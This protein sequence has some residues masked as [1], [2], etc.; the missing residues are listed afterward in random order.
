MTL[1]GIPVHKTYSGLKGIRL[2]NFLISS[3][4]PDE[5][6]NHD[7]FIGGDNDIGDGYIYLYGNGNGDGNG[8]VFTNNWN[9]IWIFEIK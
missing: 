7:D 9:N 5:G 4:D 8:M 6:S 1:V 2:C 3:D